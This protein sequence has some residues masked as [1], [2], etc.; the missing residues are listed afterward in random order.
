MYRKSVRRLQTEIFLR[1]SLEIT[2]FIKIFCSE[3]LVEMI[4]G[5]PFAINF[6]CQIENQVSNYRI[7]G[8]SSLF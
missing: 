3:I 7:L 4:F 1:I 2:T 8:A 6:R 5:W